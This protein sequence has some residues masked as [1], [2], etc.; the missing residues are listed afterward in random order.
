MDTNTKDYEITW[1]E[2]FVYDWQYRR[3]Q[4]F[5]KKLADCISHADKGNQQKLLQGFPEE[6]QAIINFQTDTNYW[7]IVEEKMES[8]QHKN[9]LKR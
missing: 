2:R 4:G 1:G 6:T 8:K 9:T 5:G 7:Q 3:L